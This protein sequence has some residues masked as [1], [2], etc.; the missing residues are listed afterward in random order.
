M[1]FHLYVFLC[2][3]LNDLN[4]RS[5]SHKIRTHILYCCFLPWMVVTWI[6]KTKLNSKKRVN[7]QWWLHYSYPQHNKKLKIC[8]EQKIWESH[9]KLQICLYIIFQ[10]TKTYHA[11]FF[12]LSSF[13][14]FSHVN[15]LIIFKNM[16]HSIFFNIQTF[17]YD[18]VNTS[19]ISIELL[20]HIARFEFPLVYNLILLI[21]NPCFR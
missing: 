20:T 19:P 8:C 18:L 6:M 15:C 7:Q 5:W 12:K 9:K 16:K 10:N 4:M 1:V 21:M 11:L 13:L 17:N 14:T 2:V 3:A